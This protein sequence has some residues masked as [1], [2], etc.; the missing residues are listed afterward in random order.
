MNAPPGRKLVCSFTQ[1]GMSEEIW[2]EIKETQI[3]IIDTGRWLLLYLRT[4]C[5]LHMRQLNLT[6]DRYLIWFWS[7]LSKCKREASHAW[8]C[9]ALSHLGLHA[10]QRHHWTLSSPFFFNDLFYDAP[11]QGWW[12]S[13]ISRMMGVHLPSAA[14]GALF[15][16]RTKTVTIGSRAFAI[17]SL[18]ACNSLPVD[19]RNPSLSLLTFRENFRP[20][21]TF[22]SLV[23]DIDVLTKPDV[24]LFCTIH[25]NYLKNT[26]I[27]FIYSSI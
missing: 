15:V 6:S 7:H 26:I 8:V 1:L 2:H 4:R 5:F 21:C 9:S 13:R 17:S 16:P 14:T 27:L 25:I 18:C 24:S 19:L 22:F 3:L 10:G 12:A 23:K 11:Y 20:A